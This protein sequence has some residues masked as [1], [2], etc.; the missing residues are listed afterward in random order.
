MDQNIATL[1]N[2]IDESENIVFFGGAG[3]S[4][5]SG[6]PDFRR[7]AGLHTQPQHLPP[8]PRLGLHVLVDQHAQR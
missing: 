6:L 1:Q 3:V 5:E 4:T 7:A 8:Q 2:W